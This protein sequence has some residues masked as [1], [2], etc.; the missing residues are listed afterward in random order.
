MLTTGV[1]RTRLDG[2]PTRITNPARTIVDCVR[3][4]RIIDRETA[5]EAM[6]EGL[7]G[8][9]VTTNTLLRMAKACGVFDLMRRDIELLS[10]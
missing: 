8:R 7:H 2:V 4:S 6:R 3:L 9:H 5:I 10:S 1:E